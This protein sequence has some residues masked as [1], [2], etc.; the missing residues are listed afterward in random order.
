[1]SGFADAAARPHPDHLSTPLRPPK[2]PCAGA[3]CVWRAPDLVLARE[4]PNGSTG[5]LYRL[6]HG[7]PA[8]IVAGW[9]F[10]SKL[11]DNL[12]DPVAEWFTGTEPPDEAVELLRI[13]GF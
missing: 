8:S 6:A 12:P 10:G 2:P 3:V 11:R 7:T 9:S 4:T 1:M 13:A 5:R